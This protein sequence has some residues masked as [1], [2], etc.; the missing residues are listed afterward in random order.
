MYPYRVLFDLGMYEVLLVLGFVFAL[1]YFRLLAD[2]A[3]FGAS[4]QNICILGGL[5]GLIGGYTMAVVTQAIYNAI[6]SGHFEIASNTG[7]TFYG[8]LVG[9]IGFYVLF[10]FLAGRFFLSRGE[11]KSNF[12]RMS[13]IAAGA[14]AL[15]HAFGRIGCLFAGCCHGAVTNAWYGIYHVRMQV[16]VI[17]VQL[18]E[19]IF[20]LAL[21]A[22]LTLRFLRGK[23]KGLAVYM[24]AYAIWRFL[25]EYLRA[26]DRGSTVVSFLSPSQLT[27]VLL[28][29]VGAAILLYPSVMRKWREHHES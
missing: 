8:G 19:A 27:S 25:A 2:R 9:G 12:G 7:A 16:K 23:R 28:L 29:L 3:G 20:L 11:A 6:A 5:V 18:Y 4:L 1:I 17:P 13:D 21:S 14:I 24:V 22:A 10:Y 15:A 26:D